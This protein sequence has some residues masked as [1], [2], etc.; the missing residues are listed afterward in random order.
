MRKDRAI[1]A[2][3]RHNG[4]RGFS[5]I[6]LLV[7]IAIVALLVSLSLPAIHKARIEAWKAVSLANIRSIAQ[8]GSMYQ[9][10]H[11]GLLPL[12]RTGVPG[13]TIGL[14]TGNSPSTD[15]PLDKESFA[16]F[17]AWG[18]NNQWKPWAAT[19]GGS[20]AVRKV[21]VRN[22]IPAAIRPLNP[23]L[24]SEIIPD[25]R[26]EPYN[27]ELRDLF[28]LPVC[29]DPSDRVGH[30]QTLSVANLTEVSDYSG[31]PNPD[32]KSCYDDV[33]TSYQWQA[34]WLW[35]T[36]AQVGRSNNHPYG[37]YG[38]AFDLGLR[39][40]KLADTYA[41]SRMIWINDEWCDIT[42]NRTNDQARDVNNYGDVNK[43]VVAFVDG[44]SKY[45]KIIP[46]GHRNPKAFLKP[47]LVPGFWNSE[48]AVVFPFLKK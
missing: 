39:R 35:Q 41:P 32:G 30:Q 27:P 12:T 34:K 37:P 14:G 43:S 48:Y 33:G 45:V 17:S 2:A 22:D 10:D 47:W 21:G 15:T 9:N 31:R 8:A 44:H 24:T 38:A 42:L 4:R 3:F 20:Y 19:H 29:K 7:V 1:R 6:E 40:F 28:Q 46:G 26:A 16:T 5:L 13:T 18:K 36:Y 11:K 23:Y 25:T